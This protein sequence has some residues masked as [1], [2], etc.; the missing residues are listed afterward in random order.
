[1]ISVCVPVGG[2]TPLPTPPG[3]ELWLGFWRVNSD[4][5]G[6]GPMHLMITKEAGGSVRVAQYSRDFSQL[7]DFVNV[8][9]TAKRLRAE[10][11]RTSKSF[12]IDLAGTSNGTAEGTWNLIHPQFT[13]E[14][15]LRGV[16]I[17]SGKSGL[18]GELPILDEGLPILNLVNLLA[19]SPSGSAEEFRTFWESEIEAKYYPL[20]YDL[21]YDPA[22]AR[23]AERARVEAIR[24]LVQEGL[25]EK[26]RQ[27]EE[28]LKKIHAELETKAKDLNFRNT[29]LIVPVPAGIEVGPSRMEGQLIMRVSPAD[30]KAASRGVLARE[31]LTV[32]FFLAFPPTDETVAGR[33]IRDGLATFLA[34]RHG[35]AAGPE[36]AFPAW[37]AESAKGP[38]PEIARRVREAMVDRVKADQLPR[39]APVVVG[40]A[41]AEQLIA[42][43]PIQ[44]LRSFT[45]EKFVNLFVEFLAGF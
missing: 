25:G 34:I 19:N 21:L 37:N 12:R 17:H 26:A 7:L 3:E 39:E 44:E 18:I 10:Y 9:V 16:K 38:L 4:E 22:D 29:F 40:L 15:R 2:A 33:S 31:K 45:R 23:S 5:P 41:F 11:R 28:T 14:T 6:S 24:K 8:S 43:Y 32:P 42:A 36:A 1:M 20:V 30:P 27:V 35:F 13:A